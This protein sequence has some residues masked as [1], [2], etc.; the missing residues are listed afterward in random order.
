VLG[1]PGAGKGTQAEPLAERL[2]LDYLS[3]G[4]LLREE[5]RRGTELGREAV[6]FMSEGGLVPDELVLAAILK[7]IEDEGRGVVLD[8]FP[9]T[10]AQ[11][12]ALGDALEISDAVL[13]DVPDDVLAERIAGRRAHAEPGERR[14]DDEPE[15]VRERL[16]VYHELTE[17]VI[18]YY[19]ERGILRRIDGARPPDE[20]QG[21]LVS[22]LG[23][24]A[25]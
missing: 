19:E 6:R 7:R 13:I 10:L 14:A 3:T 9:R 2:G 24:D 25:A 1:P 17:P 16:R 12:R 18:G 20:I 15:T 5:A 22:A 4:E 11:A 8:G 21:E 23:R